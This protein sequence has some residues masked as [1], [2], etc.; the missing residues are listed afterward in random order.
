MS[1]SSQAPFFT[2]ES[3]RH[4]CLVLAESYRQVRIEARWTPTPDDGYLLIKN[5]VSS[6]QDGCSRGMRTDYHVLFSKPWQLP[7]LYFA[8]FWEDTLEPL[9]LKEIYT[10]VV[11]KS[12]QEAVKDV[13]ILG[14]ISHGDHPQLGIPFYFIH[15]CRTAD[16]L[17]DIQADNTKISQDELIQVWLGL[18]GGVVNIPTPAS[19]LDESNS[20][21][22]L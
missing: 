11:E 6:R 5:V 4:A 13:G 12:S 22:V 15:P 18:V 21:F 3:F 9:S 7:V 1:D 8:S 20:N 19:N 2:G 10:H 14:G 16:L 17:N